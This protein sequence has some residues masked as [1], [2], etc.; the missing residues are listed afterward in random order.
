MSESATVKEGDPVQIHF[1]GR[2]PDGTVFESSAGGDP[3][4]F[5]AGSEEVLPG[6]SQGVVG[7]AAGETK[8]VELAP[9]SGFGDRHEELVRVV[10]R[11][12]LPEDAKV[13]DQLSAQIGDRELIVWVRELD[14][15][16]AVLD[17]NHP[18]AGVTVTFSIT[19]VAIESA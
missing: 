7:M 15:D 12:Q 11:D 16:R 19:L 5:V 14:D 17:A 1:E 4:T 8:D 18:L 10:E 13:G 6:V 3:L 2:L 9:E